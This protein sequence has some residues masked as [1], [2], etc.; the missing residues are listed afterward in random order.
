M[1]GG[2]FI[3][4]GSYGC[5]FK[6]PV[7]CKNEA[8]TVNNGVGKVFGRPEFADSEKVIMSKIK[9]IDPKF[10]WTLPLLHS[11]TV[12][13][14]KQ[15]DDPD[16]CDH[17]VKDIR[18][19]PQLIFK[20]GGVDLQA[21]IRKTH[22]LTQDRKR[23]LFLSIFQSMV[24]VLHGLANLSDS[25]LIHLDLKPSNLLFDGKKLV[26]IDFGLLTN[27]TEL[28]NKSKLSLLS[29]DY[30]YYPPEF[31]LYALNNPSYDMFRT[32]FQ[33]NLK[34]HQ[35]TEQEQQHMHNQLLRFHQI[36]NSKNRRLKSKE[37]G[38][39]LETLIGKV[40]IYSL[41]VSLWYMYHMLCPSDNIYTF[42]CKTLIDKMINVNPYE[43]IC[44][45]EALKE[46]EYMLKITGNFK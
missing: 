32:S 20:D 21:I 39:E 14:F 34:Y 11:C 44:C 45:Q 13:K 4:S 26:V 43:R 3:A 17:V 10:T 15:S 38:E 41:G 19:Y 23:K 24:P 9:K 46:L 36:I 1:D 6:K 35:Q 37:L 28:Y 8:N 5:A 18:S 40:D 30:P 7:K 25:N 12:D 2:K 29:Y 27:S 31:K 16:L 22:Q 33:L 42:M